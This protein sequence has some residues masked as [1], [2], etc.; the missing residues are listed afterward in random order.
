MAKDKKP[1]IPIS[2]VI[3]GEIIY[4]ATCLSALV[5]L[6]GTLLSFI[7]TNSAIDVEYLLNSVLAGKSVVQI[8]ANSDLITPPNAITYLSIIRSGE[9]VTVFGISLGV[10]SVVPATL[11][12][13]FYLWRSRNPF[14]ALTAVCAGLISICAFIGA[15]AVS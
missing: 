3:Y 6:F 7:E 1:P 13:S 2:G 15:V 10:F 5:V 12:A 11:F 9:A 14:F 4:W 8:W